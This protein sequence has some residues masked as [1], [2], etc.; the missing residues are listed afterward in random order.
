MTDPVSEPRISDPDDGPAVARRGR[1]AGGNLPA[2]LNSFVGRR[3][4]LADIK[5]LTSGFRLVTLCGIGGVG[6]TRLAQRAAALALRAFPDGAWFVDLSELVQPAAPAVQRAGPAV[7][8]VPG[9]E[10]LAR[11]VAAALGLPELAEDQPVRSL[12]EHLAP[13]CLLLVLDN[14]E[15][16][17]PAGAA[18]VNALLHACP[19]LRIVATSREPLGIT[20][21]VTYPVPPLPMPDP[22]EPS[23]ADV[24][25]CDSVALFVARAEAVQP[26]FRLTGDKVAEV[27]DICRRL[28]GLPLAIELAAARLRVLTA[29]QISA[30]LN[31]RFA[32]LGSGSR[33]VPDRQHSLRNCVDWSF[34]LCDAAEQ[35][36]WARLSVFSGSFE[37]D[38]VEG[39]CAGEDLLTA[40]LLNLTAALIDK[41]ILSREDHGPVV[42]YRMLETIRAYGHDR[43][44]AGG[45]YAVLPRR[46][47]DWYESLVEQA[48]GEWLSDRQ[49]YWLDRLHQEH[50]E[51]RQAV[52]YCL[53]E[54]GG[55]ER[56]MGILVYLP[57]PHW[58]GPGMLDE[59]RG[60]LDRAL[61]LSPA[62][63]ALR[64]R[65]L[66][67]ASRLALARGDQ[68]RGKQLLDEGTEVAR[69]LD[70]AA[71]LSFAKFLRGT[72]ALYAGD[73]PAA[74]EFLECALAI[75]APEPRQLLDQR[76]HV[77]SALV[78]AAGLAGD[79]ERAATCHE[80][81][82][83]ITEPREEGFHRANAMWAYGLAAWQQGDLDTAAARQVASL[84]LRQERGLEDPLGTARCLAALARIEA[85]REPRRAAVLLG[86]AD[87]RWT[88]H[89][90]S[91][92]SYR[93]LGNDRE[94]CE[95]QIRRGLDGTSY[96][97]AI[98]HGRSLTH[99]DAVAYALQ[100]FREPA[101][102][103]VP[104]SET[105]LTRREEEVAVL[106][107]RGLSNRDIA[108]SLVISQRTAESH[109]A[110]ILTKQGFTSR[111]QIAAWIA[112]QSI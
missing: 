54:P 73:L 108:K 93:N 5:R 15:H 23:E 68:G 14:C 20:G 36:L 46:H 71:A 98:G 89:G 84:R 78:A 51:L 92:G 86:A 94:N 96:E 59:A 49:A 12:C 91:V 104:A 48:A 4:E 16:L 72:A 82:L 30:R 58:R 61:A 103:P 6:K 24:T 43:L 1:A 110:N 102:P 44:C 3:R 79:Q 83:E 32:L 9:S 55:A 87:A 95:R 25:G 107:A 66:L 11:V 13:R 100:E 70:D 41:S 88:E 101:T 19:D 77:L 29:G 62:P 18:L 22:G 39:I 112:E 60:R 74:V 7:R 35:R 80:E 37:L 111:A 17:L 52:D 76:L 2:E 106:V 65:A 31:D 47:R 42:R 8:P 38:A 28:D 57:S 50:T 33:N 85:G 99:A 26:G 69:H 56:A 34:D 105:Q 109:V 64:A 67:L 53:T 27:A 97:D 40:D 45:E 21:E 75:L 81:I 63:T 10:T 90:V